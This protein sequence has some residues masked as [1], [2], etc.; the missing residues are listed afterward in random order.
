VTEKEV[1]RYTLSVGQ[2]IVAKAAMKKLARNA[3]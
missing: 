1:I 2:K 3:R